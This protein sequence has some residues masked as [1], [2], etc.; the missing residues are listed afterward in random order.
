M[1][2]EM[3]SRMERHSQ[4]APAKRSEQAAKKSSKTWIWIVVGVVVAAA[5]GAGVYFG[6]FANKSA[7]E[8]L[9]A[10]VPV[11]TGDVVNLAKQEELVTFTVEAENEAAQKAVLE[12][13]PKS[14]FTLESS[15]EMEDGNIYA[16]SGD[17]INLTVRLRAEGDKYF[18]DYAAS[19]ANVGEK[20][21]PEKTE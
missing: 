9:P 13:L 7:V 1:T 6:F 12:D 21:I 16:F 17:G 2:E 15:N 10:S 3:P 8:G 11:A 4:E 20:A 18:V 14:G 5:I 19:G